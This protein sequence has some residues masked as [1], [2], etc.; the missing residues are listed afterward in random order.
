MKVT[1]FKELTKQLDE[2]QKALKELDGQLGVVQFDPHDPVSIEA[3]I[4]EIE[5]II[6]T[7]AGRYASNAIIAP[8]IAGMKE[9]Y[10]HGILDRA[11]EARLKSGDDDGNS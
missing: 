6:N 11:T 8:M 1:G 5:Q 7:K 3:A 4:A 2:A 10:R 9:Q